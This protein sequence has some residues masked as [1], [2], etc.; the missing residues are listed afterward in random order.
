[1]SARRDIERNRKMATGVV[2]GAIFKHTPRAGEDPNKK[3]PLYDIQLEIMGVKLRLA[4]WPKEKS[5]TGAVEYLPISGDYARDELKRLVDVAV[6]V[7]AGA[8][9]AASSNVET[10]DIPF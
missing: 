4:A 3:H 5:K 8:T 10:E 2:R 7:G 1:M 9:A 6:T